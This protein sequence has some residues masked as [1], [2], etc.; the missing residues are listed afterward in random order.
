[1]RADYGSTG[2]W[3]RVQVELRTLIKYTGFSS[4]NVACYTTLDAP[5]ATITIAYGINSSRQIAGYYEDDKEDVHGFLRDRDG[6]YTTIDVPGAMFT[7]AYGI[8]SSGQI[9]GSYDDDATAH[10]FLATPVP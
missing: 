2:R 10:G 1:V 7:I 3:R 5:D 8:N 6:S 9:V 4:F